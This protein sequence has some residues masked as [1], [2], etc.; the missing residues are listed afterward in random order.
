MKAEQILSWVVM[1]HTGVDFSVNG[2][3]FQISNLGRGFW[4]RI[5]RQGG[6]PLRRNVS[7]EKIQVAIDIATEFT[8]FLNSKISVVPRQEFEQMVTSAFNS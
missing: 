7:I 2:K 6:Q 8:I 3:I 4:E 1:N 5:L